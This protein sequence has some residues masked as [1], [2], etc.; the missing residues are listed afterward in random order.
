MDTSGL[1]IVFLL[2]SHWMYCC[3]CVCSHF[4]FL[5]VC[6]DYFVFL[7]CIGT[8]FNVFLIYI[9]CY[10]TCLILNFHHCLNIIIIVGNISG[11]YKFQ[12]FLVHIISGLQKFVLLW[13]VFWICKFASG[14]IKAVYWSRDQLLNQLLNCFIF[15]VTFKESSSI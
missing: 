4:E 12:S 1:S 7:N 13:G 5:L 9:W 14:S 15:N 2:L 11:F 8:T 3:V 6:F 10:F